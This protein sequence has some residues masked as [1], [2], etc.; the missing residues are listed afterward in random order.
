MNGVNVRAPALGNLGGEPV[1]RAAE[2]VDATARSTQAVDDWP[3][4][5]PFESRNVWSAPR[6]NQSPNLNVGR[7][8]EWP[9]M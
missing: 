6:T 9:R 2:S 1:R 3:E 4:P 7:E 8:L 5:K